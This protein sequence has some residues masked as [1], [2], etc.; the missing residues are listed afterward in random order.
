MAMRFSAA[1]REIASVEKNIFHPF[2]GRLLLNEDGTLA[3][4]GGM[5]GLR[6]HDEAE[7]DGRVFVVMQKRRQASAAYPCASCR[8]TSC[9]SRGFAA[10]GR[11]R[12]TPS[13]GMNFAETCAGLMDAILK[14]FAV[15]EVMWAIKGDEIVPDRVIARDQRRF[16]FDIDY[17]LH[18]LTYVDM[19]VGED[20]PPRKF[21]VHSFGAKDGSPYGL[22]LGSRLYWYVFFKRQGIG[23]WLALLDKYGMPTAVGKYPPQASADLK[24]KLN[25]CVERDRAGHGGHHSRRRGGLAPRKRADWRQRRLRE[26]CA[27][28]GRADR[29]DRAWRTLTTNIGAAG[30][31]A[32]AG[33]H[34]DVRLELARADGELLAETLNRTLVRWIVDLN[35]PGAPYP[36]LLWDIQEPDDLDAR[37]DRDG[38]LYKMGFRP[39]LKYITDTYGA[40]WVPRAANPAPAKPPELAGTGVRGARTFRRLKLLRRRA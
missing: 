5:L 29:R 10:R 37:A 16:R 18:L 38:K 36:R 40:G 12:E 25:V 6:I 23:F 21:I 3:Q 39:T 22:G 1:L 17:R 28:H 32:A 4:R 2:V 7:R 19:L 24:Q 9:A 11:S 14:G 8:A 20:L 13:Q 34:N 31:R 27:L 35:M 15:G 26:D 30:S 33:I